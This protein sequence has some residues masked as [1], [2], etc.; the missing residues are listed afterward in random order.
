MRIDDLILEL[1]KFKEA[2]GNVIVRYFDEVGEKDFRIEAMMP[3]N[4]NTTEKPVWCCF[5]TD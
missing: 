1:E 4:I 2:H 5:L 3:V